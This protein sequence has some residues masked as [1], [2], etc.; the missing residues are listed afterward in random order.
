MGGQVDF[1][2]ITEESKGGCFKCGDKFQPGHKYAKSV[3]LHVVEEL[4]QVM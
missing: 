3:P 4:L 2:V 1:L